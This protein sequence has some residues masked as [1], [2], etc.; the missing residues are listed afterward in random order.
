MPKANGAAVS[1]QPKR[2]ASAFMIFSKTFHA[3]FRA[4]HPGKY[5][6]KEAAKAAGAAW[7]S[8]G[9]A[10]K[11]TY[12]DQYVKAKAKYDKD[13]SNYDGPIVKRGKKNKR[14]EK[15]FKDPNAPKRPMSAYILF[16]NDMRNQVRARMGQDAAMKDVTSE[17]ARQW[18]EADGKTKAKFDAL[19]Q[20]AKSK[21]TVAIAKYK[22]GGGGAKAS[23]PAKG[24]GR[25][26][27]VVEEDDDD[28][29]EDD[30]DEDDEEESD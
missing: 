21:Y 12:Q 2:P 27:A 19:A 7:G 22:A 10:K 17:L 20:A 25:K 28:E 18:R 29:E 14:G 24:R 13:M 3:D 15:K 9:D 26:P 11:K 23:S 6:V 8:L 1:E 5:D 4:K 30:E 16:A